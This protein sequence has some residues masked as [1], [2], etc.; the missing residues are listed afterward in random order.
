MSLRYLLDFALLQRQIFHL[1]RGKTLSTGKVHTHDDTV[2]PIK[3][4][5]IGKSSA[6]E[7]TIPLDSSRKAE[8]LK[9]PKKAK[10]DNFTIKR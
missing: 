1:S 10:G 4:S 5:V 6:T 7:K 3:P 8:N 2:K 9:Q